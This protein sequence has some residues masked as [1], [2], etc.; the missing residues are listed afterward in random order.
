MQA[1]H[2]EVVY[3]GTCTTFLML[4]TFCYTHNYI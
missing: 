2:L 1:H 4:I 3:V